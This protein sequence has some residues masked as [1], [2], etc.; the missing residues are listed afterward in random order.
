MRFSYPPYVFLM[1]LPNLFMFFDWAQAAWM[2]LNLVSIPTLSFLLF[3]KAPRWILVT[4][5]LVYNVLYGAVVGN[6]SLIISLVLLLFFGYFVIR[7][8]RLAGV[9]I[10]MGFLLAWSTAKPQSVWLYLIFV[11]LFSYR[12][13]LWPLLRAFAISIAGLLMMPFLIQSSWLSEWISILS[14]YV[15]FTGQN[16][17]IMALLALFYPGPFTAPLVNSAFQVAALIL[18]PLAGLLIYQWWRSRIPDFALLC[19]VA[20]IT[21]LLLPNNSSADQMFLLIPL[22]LWCLWQSAE[23]PA[24]RWVWLAFLLYSYLTFFAEV[25][26]FI[27]RA[28]ISGQLLFFSAWAIWMWVFGNQCGNRREASAPPL[29]DYHGKA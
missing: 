7:Q 13:R 15:G 21:Y 11:L 16:R 17:G 26:R 8:G 27:P 19:A 18:I 24:A 23:R 3:P 9:Q 6:F 29:D 4:T 25:L 2:A 12:A 22:L 1:V 20:A 10:A 5:P 14:I 28:I